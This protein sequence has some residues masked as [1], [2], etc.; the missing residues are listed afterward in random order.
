MGTHPIFESDFDCPTDDSKME[1]NFTEQII[2]I[3]QM[4]QNFCSFLLENGITKYPGIKKDLNMHLRGVLAIFD[5]FP[6]FEL[7]DEDRKRLGEIVIDDSEEDKE[8]HFNKPLQNASGGFGNLEFAFSENEEEVK[9]D[10]L[11]S[12]KSSKKA[13]DDPK[14]TPKEQK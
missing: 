14:T 4:F 11:K 1:E 10:I 5:Q 7:P 13:V 9:N 8:I 6:S 12:Q 3:C 2:E